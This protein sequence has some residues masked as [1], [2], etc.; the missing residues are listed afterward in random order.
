MIR[1]EV[2]AW[3]DVG[4]AREVNEDRVFYQV[5]AASEGDPVVLCIVADG[6]GGHLA[7][8][9]ASHW[10]VETLKRELAELFVPLDPR[11]TVQVSGGDLAALAAGANRG[12]RPSDIVMMRRL[13]AAVE[14]ANTAV[15]QYTLHRPEEA[16][17]AGSTLTMALVKG[18][19]AYVANVGDSRAYVLRQGQLSQVTRDHS[20]V[21]ELVAAGQLTAQEA[22]SHPQAG[23]ITRCLGYLD[24]V[25]V[26][27]EPHTLESG[28]CLMLCSDGLWEAL[29]D[30]E[31]MVRI[32]QSTPDLDV[33]ARRLVESA[34]QVGGQDNISVVLLRIVENPDIPI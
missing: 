27:V 2:A 14:R 18:K 26:D 30:P 22:Y 13:R 17:G 6:M 12:L 1:P 24:E 21:A 15:R 10:A 3:S 5:L 28:D 20:L 33:A 4:Q 31:T 16:M 11:D 23:L 32:I 19:Q 29:R 7:G 25:E 34:N 8:E 9:V